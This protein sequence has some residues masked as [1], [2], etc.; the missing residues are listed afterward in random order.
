MGYNYLKR[1]I[2]S[3]MCVV[4]LLF[5][6]TSSVW[7]GGHSISQIN[8]I[9]MGKFNLEGQFI[10]GILNAKNG[11][12]EN[13]NVN[14]WDLRVDGKIATCL[15]Y[16]S[17]ANTNDSMTLVESP[18]GLILPNGDVLQNFFRGIFYGYERIIGHHF[19]FSCPDPDYERLGS[20]RTGGYL[21]PEDCYIMQQLLVWR[22]ACAKFC[23]PSEQYELELMQSIFKQLYSDTISY[24]KLYAITEAYQYMIQC[25]YQSISG[26][27]NEKY[28]GVQIN[29]FRAD[30]DTHQDLMTWDV[31]SAPKIFTVKKN[32]TIFNLPVANAIYNFS[33]TEDMGNVFASLS[34]NSDGVMNVNLEEGTCYM[35]EAMNPEGYAYDDRVY[36]IDVTDSNRS[37]DIS[38]NEITNTIEFTKFDYDTKEIINGEGKFV[39]KEYNCVDGQYRTVG[40]VSYSGDGKY[41]LSNANT[42]EWH[43]ISGNVTCNKPGDRLYYTDANKGIFIVTEEMAPD[44]YSKFMPGTEGDVNYLMFKMQNSM[45]AKLEFN[46]PSDVSNHTSLTNEK[47]YNGVEV[48]KED[49]ISGTNLS[50]AEFAID[51]CIDGKYY[52]VGQLQEE[53]TEI[54]KKN[55]THYITSRNNKYSFHDENGNVT[56]T[57]LDNETPLHYT[58][59]NKGNYFLREVKSPD[60]YE[61]DTE[62]IRIKLTTKKYG[63]IKRTVTNTGKSTNVTIMKKD[64]VTGDAVSDKAQIMVYENVDG[65]WMESGELVFNQETGIYLSN[66]G[67]YAYHNIQGNVHLTRNSLIYT[68]VNKGKFMLKEITPPGNYQTGHMDNNKLINEPVYFE[69]NKDSGEVTDL[70]SDS[71]TDTGIINTLGLT[72]YD[73][74][75]KGEI[76]N[77]KGI[78]TVEECLDDGKWYECGNLRFN[79]KN[80][81]YETDDSVFE[82]HKNDGSKS[83]QVRGYLVYTN[84]NRGRFRIVEKK[85]PD[86]YT[87]DSYNYE[88]NISG[89]KNNQRININELS[90]APQDLGNRAQVNLLK[91]DAI[92]LKEVREHDGSFQI[93][94]KAGN[95]WQLCGELVYSDKDGCYSS[96]GN[97]FN[98]HN[99][100][101]DIVDNKNIENGYLYYTEANKG[102][103]RIRE[104]K[105]P[106]NYTLGEYKKDIKITRNNEII[107]LTDIDTAPCDTGINGKIQL[108]KKDKIHNTLLNNAVFTVFE[109]SD[110]LG[111]W[112]EKGI[113]N[114]VSDGFYTS[115][116]NYTTDNM[117]KFKVIETKAPDG[118]VN[119]HYESNEII[120]KDDGQVDNLKPIDGIENT[121]I[122]LSVSKKS[123][124]TGEEIIGAVLRIED[125]NGEIVEKWTTD[126]KEHLIEKLLPGKYTLIEERAPEGYII[127]EK[128]EFEIIENEEIQKVVM[129][130]KE[131]P[132][133]KITEDTIEKETETTTEK[134]KETPTTDTP[135]IDAPLETPDT[136]VPTGDKVNAMLVMLLFVVIIIVCLTS[137]ASSDKSN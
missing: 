46:T 133:E 80:N 4:T 83:A 33:Y 9:G 105:A 117:G 82:Y 13:E 48:V 12:T 14:M 40:P 64:A 70:T 94:E 128:I 116:I 55:I 71:I 112:A 110:E 5:G 36:R 88:F 59:Y 26:K 79:E 106:S 130:D 85:A 100:N 60:N 21:T 131:K 39:I 57:I 7:A 34:T 62:R 65:K 30:N 124:A 29:Y 74:L 96:K 115:D 17:M 20:A 103:F 54:N 15:D 132:E 24:E 102:V 126:G 8:N 3:L 137:I 50:G 45:N 122:R 35:Q 27:Y 25:V 108:I 118:Y 99:T 22:I 92:T 31:T 134:L 78:F 113:M 135:Q 11:R 114:N 76:K 86:N 66:G 90:N 68:D 127:A 95:K 81:A 58:K 97:T 18:A 121:P 69:I 38:E 1:V 53:L 63:V 107:S 120:L 98:F 136:P 19:K 41:N 44:G 125:S 49:S 32:G 42:F 52:E 93:Y 129:Y 28:Q 23:N 91:Y 73:K 47:V 67:N 75:T 51:E 6:M 37:L 2:A 87:L 56:E 109:W 84:A 72:K 43:D 77:G 89:N 119:S 111:R 104:V 16:G 101:G 10:D 61:A 123:F